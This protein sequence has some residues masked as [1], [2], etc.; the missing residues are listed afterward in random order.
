MKALAEGVIKNALGEFEAFVKELN[1]SEELK[2]DGLLN[3][4]H[5]ILLLSVSDFA[6]RGGGFSDVVS[7]SVL[8]LKILTS[9]IP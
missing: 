7:F 3:L 9:M 5:L 4:R 8:Y 6:Y 1:K 2:T